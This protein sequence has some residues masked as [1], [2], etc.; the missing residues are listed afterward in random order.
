MF[1]RQEGKWSEVSYVQAFFILG[2]NPNL[3]KKYKVDLAKNKNKKIM[4]CH[5]VHY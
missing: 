1:C 5:E 4:S 3:C 2:D